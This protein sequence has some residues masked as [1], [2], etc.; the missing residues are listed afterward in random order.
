MPNFARDAEELRTSKVALR[1]QL[2]AARRSLPSDA[3]R[4]ADSKIQAALMATIRTRSPRVMA[5]YVPIG[6]EPGG[7]ELPEK[8]RHTYAKPSPS[9]ALANR[10]TLLL[11]L[12]LP[13]GDLDWA[14]Y[15]G[16]ES[17]TRGPHGLLEPSGPRLG[18]DAIAEAD[19]VVV[20][21]LAVDRRGLR[22]GKGGGSYDRALSRLPS[23]A[24]TIALLHD[25][26]LLDTVPA[27]PHDRPVRA[28]VTPREG[29]S[30]SP[31][32]TK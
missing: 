15:E 32:W 23:S 3:R 4:A 24:F 22:M 13:D 6:T 10:L 11:P 18:A 8:L 30:E 17:L 26:E 29:L 21:A 1:R 31:D 16:P 28:V 20:P 14:P 7:P 25:G 5:A 27:E 19:L 2:L 12:L 9:P